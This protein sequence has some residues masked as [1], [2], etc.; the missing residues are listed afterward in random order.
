MSTS[1]RP[2]PLSRLPLRALVAALA[3]TAL[4]AGCGG[5]KFKRAKDA[6]RFRALPS[7]YEV[8]RF[9]TFA[10]APQ[11]AI[12]VGV[13]QTTTPGD[14]PDEAAALQEFEPLARRGGCDALTD[15]KAKRKETTK[16][17]KQRKVDASGKPIY[18]NGRPVYE[19]VDI[20]TVNHVWSATCV[21]TPEAPEAPVVQR[22]TS[23]GTGTT[24]A[25]AGGTTTEP[26]GPGTTTTEP[27][28]DGPAA[29]PNADAAPAK[30]GV[31]P[32]VALQVAL[33]FR[34]WSQAMESGD[35]KQLCKLV[36]PM[37]AR[38]DVVTRDPPMKMSKAWGHDDACA[39]LEAGLLANYVREWGLAEVHADVKYLLPEL[40][41]IH[42]G[43]PYAE[44]DDA[45]VERY[46]G[47]L[48][49]RRKGKKPLDCTMYNVTPAGELFQVQLD[50]KS[51]KR[52]AVLL[53]RAPDGRYLVARYSHLR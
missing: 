26:A 9:A 34:Q 8:K 46:R 25:G 7:S 28:S 47:E 30:P 24:G 50:C 15:M 44:L 22:R 17:K 20:V 43:K 45:T 14:V 11:P 2:L 39:E 48:M 10:E 33:T 27:A 52:Y 53:Q 23:G 4:V 37:G 41:A 3:S 12:L 31:S 32:E 51:A 19:V 40:F 42:G 18:D 21:R 6:P 13:M 29:D 16:Q 38:F 35:T 36:S 1:S 5:A 49:S